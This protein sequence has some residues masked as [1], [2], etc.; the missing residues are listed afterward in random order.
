MEAWRPTTTA[1]TGATPL[2]SRP[3][4]MA[5]LFPPLSSFRGFTLTNCIPGAGILSVPYA[6]A[7]GG[8][9]SILLLFAIALVT[10]Y[11]GLL[12]R[13]C[14]EED[15]TIITYL[16]IGEPAFGN[17]GRSIVSVFMNGELYLIVAGFLIVEGY[18][19]HNLFPEVQFEAYGLKV[20]GRAGF[21][22][23]VALI[24][25]PSVWLDNLS[26]LP[27]ISATS[28]MA[29]VIIVVSIFW[30]GAF[31]GIGFHHK[32]DLI[33]WSGVPTAVSLH[34]FCYC[35]HTDFPT[36]YNSMEKR[37]H[38]SQVLFLCFLC[39]TI[40][41]AAMAMTGSLMF[42]P[43]VDSQITLN[44][45]IQKLSSRIAVHTTLVNPLSKYALML[46]PISRATENWFPGHHK[47]RHIRILIRTSLFA[48]QV[49]CS[50]SCSFLWVLNVSHWSIFKCDCRDHTSMLVLL[51]DFKNASQL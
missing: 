38:F 41:Y 15:S 23:I 26:I 45:P 3:S 32:G 17:I 21:A 35:A 12:I 13:R 50:F 47:K 11:T 7:S 28:V 48:T 44:L 39:T 29:S 25:L 5:T 31:D 22:I 42:G 8:W 1:R 9:L 10:L 43:T 30:V 34:S 27:Y 19:L 51:E 49:L 24:I 46:E 33:S 20:G 36:L 6:L 40:I 37:H 16:D 18:N 2:P 4:S 14:I